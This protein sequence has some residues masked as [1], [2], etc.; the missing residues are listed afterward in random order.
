MIMAA[1]SASKQKLTSAVKKEFISPQQPNPVNG[2]TGLTR[3]VDIFKN[4]SPMLLPQ[5]SNHHS[6]N[7]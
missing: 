3:N 2:S 4:V 6:G 7:H 5:F 1:N